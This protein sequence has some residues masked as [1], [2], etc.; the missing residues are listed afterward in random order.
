MTPNLPNG[1]IVH[2]LRALFNKHGTDKGR[3]QQYEQAYALHLEPYRCLGRPIRLLEIG[4]RKGAS[5]RVWKE[6]FP[7]L[8]LYAVDIDADCRQHCPPDC[9]T[10]I[11]DQADPEFWETVLPELPDKLDIVIDDGSHIANDQQTTF[12]VLFPR[13]ATGGLYVLEDLHHSQGYREADAHDMLGWL[14]ATA[15]LNVWQRRY[16]HLPA[17]YTFAGAACFITTGLR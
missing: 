10:F 2:E 11:G 17:M 14:M 3:L 13:M 1:A 9:T 8:E 4:I 7:Q 12:D 5:L 16:R 6:W 15:R